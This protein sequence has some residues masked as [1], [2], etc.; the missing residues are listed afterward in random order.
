MCTW[1]RKDLTTLSKASQQKWLPVLLPKT[2]SQSR[3]DKRS[4][5][6]PAKSFE[7]CF[8]GNSWFWYFSSANI[9]VWEHTMGF[10]VQ[11]IWRRFVLVSKVNISF[12]YCG[13]TELKAWQRSPIW[14]VGRCKNSLVMHGTDSPTI[15]PSRKSR[16]F[17]QGR[18][19]YSTQLTQSK[20]ADCTTLSHRAAKAISACG[21]ML[22]VTKAFCCKRVVL[23]LQSNI[24]HEWFGVFEQLTFHLL[25][26]ITL[27]LAGY[28][29]EIYL[30]NRKK[31]RDAFIC[32]ESLQLPCR[33]QRQ[34]PMPEWLTCQST[35]L[36][37]RPT[38][39][40]V[41]KSTI[42]GLH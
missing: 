29:S 12:S 17:F 39:T 38:L 15:P 26:Q 36:A 20:C 41:I 13:N 4:E 33:E 23:C 22:L 8:K 10:T 25:E 7:A 31:C 2:D 21:T 14:S 40:S 42:S 16:D 5:I 30:E 34:D 37:T 32:I 1:I 28:A 35:S 27:A 3:Y 9:P 18:T 6:Q 24:V 19:F 11:V